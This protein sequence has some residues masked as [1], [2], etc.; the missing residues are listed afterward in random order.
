MCNGNASAV[1]H[2]FRTAFVTLP[3][4]QICLLAFPQQL[5][6]FHSLLEFFEPM[7]GSARGAGDASP[8]M[9]SVFASRRSLFVPDIRVRRAKVCTLHVGY[10][11]LLLFCGRQRLTAIFFFLYSGFLC[12]LSMFFFVFN[13]WKISTI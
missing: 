9:F 1:E 3:F 2:L 5:D 11:N 12:F 8:Q 4:A 10:I 6:F 7:T 13:R